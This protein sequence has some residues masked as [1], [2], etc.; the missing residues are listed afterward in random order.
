MGYKYHV[1]IYDLDKESFW[2]FVKLIPATLKFEDGYAN[3]YYDGIEITLLEPDTI[4]LE[5][6]RNSIETVLAKFTHRIEPSNIYSVS[7]SVKAL[8]GTDSFRKAL[9]NS[10]LILTI[11]RPW[12]K[13]GKVEDT[14]LKLELTFEN[15][16]IVELSYNSLKASYSLSLK[17]RKKFYSTAEGLYDWVKEV[18]DEEEYFL[19]WVLKHAENVNSA[20]KREKVM[21]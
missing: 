9:G 19:S 18:F 4:F 7:A 8:L 1:Y 11:G 17:H 5:G 2:Q 6:D 15:G 10:R 16:I 21:V 20:T 14:S 3:F 12:S 13:K